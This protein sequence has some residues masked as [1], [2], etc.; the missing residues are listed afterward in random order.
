MVNGII[1]SKIADLS[2]ICVPD[3]VKS[4]GRCGA[5]SED[6]HIKMRIEGRKIICVP[7]FVPAYRLSI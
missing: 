3:A 5:C 1:Y 7:V 2:L 4:I 6:W